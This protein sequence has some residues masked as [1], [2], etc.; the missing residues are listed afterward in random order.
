[1]RILCLA[2]TVACHTFAVPQDKLTTW[3]I[4]AQAQRD[5]SEQR[6]LIKLGRTETR[7]ASP[8]KL[9]YKRGDQWWTLDATNGKETK[10]DK[11]PDQVAGSTA[12]RGRG[13]RQ[14]GRG[15][16]FSESFSED[17]KVRA[18][19]S[20]N[21]VWLALEGQ[22]PVALT[23][24]GSVEK[25]LKYGQASWVYGEELG[26]NEALGVSPK[27]DYVWF[28]KF[29]ES[30]VE[31]NYVIFEQGTNKPIFEPQAYPRPGFPNPIVDIYVTST[32]R[33]SPKLVKT[34]PG[35]FDSGVGHYLYDI[36]WAP[37]GHDLFF[38]RTDRLQKVMEFC[39]L[40]PDTGNVKTLVREE[41]P[42]SYAENKLNVWY[43]DK[44]PGID[45]A[46]PFAGKA[47]WESQ[48]NG[49]I[50][51]SVL[52]LKSG[53][54]TPVTQNK[55]D[56]TRVVKIDLEK[57]VVY[58]MARGGKNPYMDQLFVVGLNGKNNR[59]ITD[60]DWNHT[61]TMSPDNRFVVDVFESCEV[62]P[63]TQVIDLKGKVLKVLASSDTSS[64]T[65]AG[66]SLPERVV[67]TT[68]DKSHTMH[69]VLRKPRHYSK[70]KKYPLIVDVY[71]GPLDA[72]SSGFS[73]RF[74]GY[75]QKTGYGIMTASFDN[76]GTGGRG[77]VQSDPLYKNMGRVEIDDQA[78]GVQSLIDKG[79][80]DIGKVGINGTSYGGYASIMC[81][82]RYPDIYNAAVAC[83]SPT[84]WINYDSIYTERYMGLYPEN[85]REYD[86][87]SAMSYA[88]QLKGSLLLYYGTS[89]ENVHPLNTLQLLKAFR[90]LGKAVEVQVGCDLGHSAVDSR[91]EM[92]FFIEKLGLSKG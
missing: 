75:D 5:N 83:S 50:N 52:D 43:L 67:Y 41:W 47:L 16:Q 34:R 70:L 72:H 36:H 57:Q 56:E 65:K 38:R 8:T 80:V 74:S 53:Q 49:F 85:K 79:I 92:E 61:V 9:A 87:G 32:T 15:G 39:A 35:P 58:Y 26:Q 12:V 40:D 71:G 46:K 48:S 7:W 55:F 68:F 42:K 86:L 69:G 51:L 45:K 24:D 23:S 89:D 66:Y 18:Y 44:Q 59:M 60:G 17:G 11:E 6:G 14:P 90:N 27:G 2:L 77:K 20:D 10:L 73:E 4:T 22:Q 30:A 82:L 54:M 28:Y 29:D 76:R 64:F 19:F 1:M 37:N 13:R 21:N 91:R 25:R 62:P 3:P 88:N 81:L 33:V 78:A 63:T 31:D 84:A